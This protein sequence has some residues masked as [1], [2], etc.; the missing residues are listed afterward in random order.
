MSEFEASLERLLRR[1]VREEVRAVIDECVLPKL[2]GVGDYVDL[3][4]CGVE[5][6]TV[7]AAVRRREL[8]A[9]KVGRKLML[10]R[11]ELAAWVESRRAD[12]ADA[13]GDD[14]GAM[15]AQRRL[16]AVPGGNR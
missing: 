12:K 8:R 14:F 2:A 16:R 13:A 4:S 6:D 7:R 15:L 1:I 10:N 9:H 11:A 5:R 3:K